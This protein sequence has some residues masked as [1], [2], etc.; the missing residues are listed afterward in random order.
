MSVHYILGLGLV[1]VATAL[2]LRDDDQASEASDNASEHD[3]CRNRDLQHSADGAGSGNPANH[4]AGGVDDGRFDA[5]PRNEHAESSDPERGVSR[6]DRGGE[7]DTAKG[8]REA[9]GITDAEFSGDHSDCAGDDGYNVCGESASGGV[10]D[11]E[12]T[13]QREPGE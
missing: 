3:D 9:E 4:R 8:C 5:F 6:D 1:A 11:G 12:A 13:S 10:A 2:T 7:P